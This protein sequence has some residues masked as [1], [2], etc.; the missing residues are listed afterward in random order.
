MQT[1]KGLYQKEETFLHLF[2][3]NC[4]GRL[5]IVLLFMAVM[6]GVA[7]LTV[8]SEREML[9]KVTGS[10]QQCIETNYEVKC[11]RIDDAVRNFT[12]IFTLPDS[13]EENKYMVDFHRY[14]TL[15]VRPHALYSTV[16]V[17]N[18]LS[19]DGIRVGIGVMG[20]VIPTINFDDM[21][22]RAGP[23][24]KDYNQRIFRSTYSGEDL[25]NNPDFGNTYNTYQGGGS[26]YD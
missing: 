4:L 26:S 23:V 10:I 7:L 20:I 21:I 14:N 17:R 11:D 12:S 5:I 18:N 13:L 24:R 22:L 15:E 1:N 19:P 25:G 3:H 16:V 8:P 9:N 2:T 6:A